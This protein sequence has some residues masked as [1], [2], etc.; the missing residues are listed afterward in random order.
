MQYFAQP[1]QSYSSCDQYLVADMSNN[2][3]NE[4]A[5]QN[6]S[7]CVVFHAHNMHQQ[8]QR[9]ETISSVPAN[10]N[11]MAMDATAI[12]YRGVQRDANA[13]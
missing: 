5:T 2:D 4:Q 8:H 10:T 1:W 3:L 13:A 12:G 9:V 6:A 7:K 11:T